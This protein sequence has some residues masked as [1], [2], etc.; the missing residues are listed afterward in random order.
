MSFT[1]IANITLFSG[2]INVFSAVSI[3]TK[4]ISG[5]QPSIVKHIVIARL[6]HLKDNSANT[7]SNT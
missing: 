3:P 6:Q 2:K 4:V 5:K 7:L 1:F